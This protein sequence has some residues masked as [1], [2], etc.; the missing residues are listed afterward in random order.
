MLAEVESS[1][2][3]EQALAAEQKAKNEVE[4]RYQRFLDQRREALFRDTQFTGLLPSTNLDLTRKAA[5]GALSVFAQRRGQDDW[6]LG[7]LPASLSTRA[8]VGSPRGLLRA[9]HGPGRRPGRP[10]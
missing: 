1:L 6:A 10:G 9:V 2:K 8:A 5:E 3:S 4:E 7:D